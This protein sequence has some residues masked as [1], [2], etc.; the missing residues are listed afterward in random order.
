[1]EYLLIAWLPLVCGRVFAAKWG[2]RNTY[3]SMADKI[4]KIESL[5]WAKE[6]LFLKKRRKDLTGLSW[7]Q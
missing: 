4:K 5:G 2:M 7:V 1:V 3:E 6:N